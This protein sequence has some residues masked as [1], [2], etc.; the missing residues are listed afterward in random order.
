[1][2]ALAKGVLAL[3]GRVVWRAKRAWSFIMFKDQQVTHTHTDREQHPRHTHDK[4]NI[5]NPQTRIYVCGVNP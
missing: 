3:E 4:N 2:I 1:M 5:P